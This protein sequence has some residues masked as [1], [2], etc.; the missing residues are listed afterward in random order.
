MHVFNSPHHFHASNLCHGRAPFRIVFLFLLVFLLFGD[1]SCEFTG[2]GSAPSGKLNFRPY[3]S[4]E[5]LHHLMSG[6]IGYTIEMPT[7]SWLGM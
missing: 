7:G 5:L 4:L 6:Y 2:N 3:A 1:V